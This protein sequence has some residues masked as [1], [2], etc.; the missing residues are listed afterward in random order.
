M[1]ASMYGRCEQGLLV[2]QRLSTT[3]YY[4][5][6]YMYVCFESMMYVTSTKRS[7][8][9]AETLHASSWSSLSIDYNKKLRSTLKGRIE[10]KLCWLNP[11]LKD[12]VLFEEQLVIETLGC[13]YNLQAMAIHEG[14]YN[15]GHY[16]SYVRDSSGQWKHIDDAEEPVPTSFETARLVNV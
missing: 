5:Y 1:Y 9:H 7:N 14:P 13:V 6:L 16:V 2:L 4:I 10:R 15:S 8:Q 11:T 12:Y 3:L